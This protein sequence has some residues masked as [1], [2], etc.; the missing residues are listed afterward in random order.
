MN[1]DLS[2]NLDE[3]DDHV[4]LKKLEA[5]DKVISREIGKQVEKHSNAEKEGKSGDALASRLKL[6]R[7][8]KKFFLFRN[9]LLKIRE[10]GN[11]NL[12]DFSERFLEKSTDPDKFFE[13]YE[14]DI[15]QTEYR[16]IIQNLRKEKAKDLV[17]LYSLLY[18][19]LSSK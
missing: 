2:Y 3:I 7:R 16:L 12:D 13:R 18:L 15:F 8:F 14:E 4:S 6:L 17:S 11:P 9:R 19:S 1:S 10:E 5:L